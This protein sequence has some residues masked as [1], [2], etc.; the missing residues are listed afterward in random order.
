LVEL[1]TDG[2]NVIIAGVDGSRTSMRAGAYAAAWR[3]A[4]DL[5]SWS[6]TS[7]PPGALA[8]L[9]PAGVVL[10]EEALDQV[11]QDLRTQVEQAARE[12]GLSVRFV[13]ARGDPF[14]ELCRIATEVRADAIV[15]GASAQAGHR[16]VGS[17]AVRLVRAGRWPVTV[18]P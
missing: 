6:F 1:G 4:R 8:T 18:V 3:A 15:V 9:V 16:L 17:L 11:A 12:R 5:A 13:A 7:P 14:S 10:A 2:P